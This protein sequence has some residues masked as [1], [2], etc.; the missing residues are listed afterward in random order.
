[1]SSEVFVSVYRA[2]DRPTFGECFI[3]DENK[4]HL[5]VNGNATELY[6]VTSTIG[7][8]SVKCMVIKHTPSKPLW[9]ES[10]DMLKMF[11][12]PNI[13]SIENYYEDYSGE[14]RFVL[15]W[16][17][18][19]LLTW[20]K[21]MKGRQSAFQSSGRSIRPSSSFRQMIIVIA[22]LA[23]NT[24]NFHYNSGIC[25]GLECLLQ[26]GMYP[27]KI[28]IKDVYVRVKGGVISAKILISEVYWITSINDRYNQELDLWEDMRSLVQV[29]KN[30]AAD[31]KT[32]HP[33]SERFFQYVGIGNVEMLQ[34]YP[35]N[36]TDERK[37]CYLM[38]LVTYPS[39]VRPKLTGAC[40]TWPTTCEFLEKLI[41]HQETRLNTTFNRK[42]F[43]DYILV[44]RDLVKHWRNLP[45]I[46]QGSLFLSSK[47]G[48]MVS[49]YM[50]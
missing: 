38:G 33:D 24:M 11:R 12:H 45:G 25:K 22:Y 17:D 4:I 19:G 6:E 48:E 34:D 14:P 23:I 7:S 20:V 3:I 46:Q 30:S 18:G 2:H 10:Y 13:I 9:F 31:G 47:D 16:V 43:Y 39:F 42:E 5:D 41:D 49:A 29:C 36:W 44:C 28:D 26:H 37:V 50:V 8:S 40:F 32:I 15:S 35:D 1:M 21:S 27:T